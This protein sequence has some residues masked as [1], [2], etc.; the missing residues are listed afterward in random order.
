MVLFHAELLPDRLKAVVPS[1]ETFTAARLNERDVAI[2]LP[3]GFDFTLRE[4][5]IRAV[6]DAFETR[7]QFGREGWEL[8]DLGRL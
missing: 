2:I 8:G 6:G 4:G 1:G 3:V 7:L 5:S